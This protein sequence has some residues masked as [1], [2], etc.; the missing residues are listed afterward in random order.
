MSDSS[1]PLAVLHRHRGPL[2]WILAFLAMAF[3][4]RHQRHSGPTYP[5][6][7]EYELAGELHPYQL[8]RSGE[9]DEG[10]L[11]EL[12]SWGSELGAE[13]HWRRY[14]TRDEYQT[15]PMQPWGREDGSSALAARLPVQ[16]PAGKLEY[17]VTVRS[18]AE[19]ARIPSASDK[20]GGQDVHRVEGAEAADTIILRY[21]N[22]VPLPLLLAHVLMMFLSMMVGL[23]TAM[24]AIFEPRRL[25]RLTTVTLIG[26][27]I[28]GLVL[29]PCVQKIAFGAFWT[30]WPH[31][32]DLTDN[33][34]LI[35]ALVWLGAFLV[36]RLRPRAVVGHRVAVLVATA[37]MLAVYLIPHSLRGSELDYQQMEQGIE[38]EDAVR[39]G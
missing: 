14:P 36:I 4:G 28:G 29:G 31:G 32:Y 34:T 11:V 16:P 5:L 33:K 15:L 30:G 17:F 27:S 6:S 3:A 21:K 24:A 22:P 20:N 23:R 1:S 9:T 35:M 2:L 13:L 26:I 18:G 10:A 38:A 19:E 39:T 7:G 25:P 8:I 37:V 12:D